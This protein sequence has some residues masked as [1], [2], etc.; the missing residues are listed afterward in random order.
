ME[1]KKIFTTLITFCLLS[2][3]LSAQSQHVIKDMWME[4]LVS[5]DS[6]ALDDIITDDA[7]II[8][9]NGL[10]ETKSENIHNVMIGKI[11]YSKMDIKQ[12]TPK[13]HLKKRIYKGTVEVTGKYQGKDFVV[14]L[15]YTEVYRKNKGSWKLSKWQSVKV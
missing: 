7:V 6:I 15:H 3:V 1:M 4:S 14:M 13:Y 9:S 8:H 2:T 12:C 10:A 11:I 5:R